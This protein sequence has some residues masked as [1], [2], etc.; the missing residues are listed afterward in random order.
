MSRVF[1]FSLLAVS[2]TNLA[3]AQEPPP[4]AL[5]TPKHE[6]LKQFVGDW[7]STNEC[8]FGLET[9]PVQT[10]GTMQSRMLGE[11]WMTSD[12][13]IKLP[14]VDADAQLTLG[15]DAEK[16]KYVGTWVDS[17]MNHLW[18]YEGNVDETGKRFTLNATG[19]AMDG[20]GTPTEYRD[21]YEFVADRKF[22][23]TSQVR[24][25]GGDWVTIMSGE[26]IRVDG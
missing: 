11:L 1:A 20:S 15:Y 26:S 8:D 21:I 25:S 18:Q 24:S 14:G 4:A 23:T 2:V 7:K 12:V 3:F 22:K 13:L 17:V 5:V 19:P 10:T 9:G 16:K 6:L